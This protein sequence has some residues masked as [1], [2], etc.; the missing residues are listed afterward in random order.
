MWGPIS[1]EPVNSIS[2]E[3]IE[4]VAFSEWLVPIY[5]STLCHVPENLITWTFAWILIG[6]GRLR[7]PLGYTRASGNS[8]TPLSQVLTT[9]NTCK[10]CSCKH[11]HSTTVVRT[12]ALRINPGGEFAL[13]QTESEYELKKK[14]QWTFL[15]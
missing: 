11:P 13:Q 4:D 3:N 10:F 14:N 1:E 2:R 8:L 12:L 7:F 6:R 9:V 15:C 5:E